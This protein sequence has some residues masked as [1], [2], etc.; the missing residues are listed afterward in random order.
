MLFAI[1][2][3]VV[4]NAPSFGF[5][6]ESSKS[7]VPRKRE[8]SRIICSS[9]RRGA[10][11]NIF[12]ASSLCCNNSPANA[13]QT[14]T[15]NNNNNNGANLPSEGEIENSIPTFWE[16]NPFDTSYETMF[17]RLDN[18]PDS[19]FY[20][21]PRFVEHIDDNAVRTLTSYISDRLLHPKD[22]VLDLCSSWTS[23]ISVG[24][25]QK[26]KHVVGLGMNSEELVAN[27]I[28]DR[29]L[30]QDLNVRPQLPLEDS[31]FDVV[32]C[33][34]SIDY[35]TKPLDVMKE[36]G[37][38]LKPG[39]TAAIFFSNR[40][41]LNKAVGI[42]AGADDIDHAYT[43]GAYLHFSNGGF[44]NITA[45]DLS[46]RESRWLGGRIVGDPLYVVKAIK[47]V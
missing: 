30:V 5:Q 43:V 36:V 25:K 31:L 23:H 12:V 10:I 41:F 4:S 45:E 38:V 26:L 17:S 11:Q 14:N 33:Q 6:V 27:P 46:T 28:L 21:E 40:L 7:F 15:N 20:A 18:S 29:F 16:E 13:V 19:I 47:K 3:I 8:E 32:L 42:W 22:V 9:S 37:R 1:A 2:W 35:L 34:L 44:E 24:T 39:G